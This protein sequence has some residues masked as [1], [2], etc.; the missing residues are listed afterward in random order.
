MTNSEK[1]YIGLCIIF[2]TLIIL[3]NLIY[4]KFVMLQI[5]FY[6]FELSAGAILYPLTF[7]I[8]DIITELYGKEK[9][10][11]CIRL[12]ICMN[13]LVTIIIMFVSY[14]PATNWS[15]IN[16]VT[17]N[18]VFSYYSVAF[19]ASIIACYIAQAIDVNLYLW[20]RKLTKGKYLWLRSNVSTCISLFI[21]TTIVISFMAMFNIFPVEQ[22]WKLIF[23]SYSWKLFFTICCTPL[24]YLSLFSIRGFIKAVGHPVASMSFPRRRE[25][26]VKREKSSF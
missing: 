15:K 26:S 24:V 21:D 1:I 20:I 4:Q 14:L 19:L 17:F 3:G 22:I 16:D 23:N 13:V 9:A 7:L 8:T 2:S 25:S 10:N 12:A 5:P 11:F 6:K 18:K